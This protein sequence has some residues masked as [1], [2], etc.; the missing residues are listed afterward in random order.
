[1]INWGIIGTG[2]IAAVFAAAL[3][4]GDSGRPLA[5]AGRDPERT[6][7]F[8]AA[9]GIP[10]AAANP[11]ALFAD[12]RIDAIYI[13]TPHTSHAALSV[14]ALEAGKPVLCEKPMAIDEAGLDAVLETAR[15]TGKLFLEGY[16]YR[17]HPQ[18]A[19]LAEL[20][21]A[22]AIGEINLVEAA[23]GFAAKYDPADR[24]FNPALGGG[25]VW[26]IGG[27]PLSMAMFVAGL[28]LGGAPLPPDRFACGGVTA[29]G[30]VDLTACAVAVWRGRIAAQLACSTGATLDPALRIHGSAGR[31][32]LP[33]PWVCDRSSPKEGVIR[34]ERESGVEELRI[35]AARTSFGYEADGFARLLAA[36]AREAVLAPFT[37][38]ESRELNRLLCRWRAAAAGMDMEAK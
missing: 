8:A 29:P 31:I 19:K 11:G 27:Y 28:S 16:M 3:H 32:V 33:D 5:V 22:K 36:G 25:A 14:A 15:R 18:T 4:A 1:M 20:L 35:P 37:P 34:I 12:P 24:L 6:G 7:N 10:E 30:G 2:R 17:W 13:A 23:F 9:N 26:D 21:R 38:V